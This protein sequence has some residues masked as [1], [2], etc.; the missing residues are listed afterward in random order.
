MSCD[1]KKWVQDNT[2]V[3]PDKSIGRRFLVVNKLRMVCKGCGKVRYKKLR[4]PS[5][6]YVGYYD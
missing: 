6:A 4:E 1:H 5:R 3:C 2:Y